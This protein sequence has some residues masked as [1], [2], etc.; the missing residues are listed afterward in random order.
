MLQSSISGPN[1][2]DI[3]EQKTPMR[4]TLA[5]YSPILYATNLEQSK[6]F[7]E[8]Y[9][10]DFPRFKL[11]NSDTKVSFLK[12]YYRGC[13][14]TLNNEGKFEFDSRFP[15]LTCFSSPFIFYIY[16]ENVHEIFNE[17]QMNGFK[18][19]PR[20]EVM[21]KLELMIFLVLCGK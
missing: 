18:I 3:V 7:Y 15:V 17:A 14:F 11:R 20:C 16:A 1:W 2:S 19:L 6:L 4:E 10:I 13:N 5:T 21:K 12:M 8:K 9:F